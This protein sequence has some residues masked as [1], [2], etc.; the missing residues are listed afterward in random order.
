MPP[1]RV[2]AR[3]HETLQV[4]ARNQLVKHGGVRE[5]RIVAAHAHQLVFVRHVG[6]RIRHVDLLA[7]EEER[8]IIRCRSGVI[9]SMRQSSRASGGIVTQS[10]LVEELLGLLREVADQLGLLAGFD[11][12]CS[13]P[14]RA[15][16]SSRRRIPC[17][18]RPSW[19]R[20]RLN[21]YSR[22]PIAISSSA[23]V[24]DHLVREVGCES[25]GADGIADDRARVVAAS[26]RG[27]SAGA[28]P[29]RARLRGRQY[30]AQ[31][32]RRRLREVQRCA[33]GSN[34]RSG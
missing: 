12:R 20:S 31:P 14:S 7:T 26:T 16:P 29:E 28:A 34:V 27:A 33:R 9:I 17:R 6:R 19:P 13:S 11:V 25:L 23:R 3:R 24:G 10:W 22:L 30:W 21:A 2:V 1:V 4:M 15:P 18:A 32:A 5:V 8:A